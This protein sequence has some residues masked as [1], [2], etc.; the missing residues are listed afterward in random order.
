MITSRGKIA[1]GGLAAVTTP[2]PHFGQICYGENNSYI[3]AD[4]V[5]SGFGLCDLA[6][7]SVVLFN[8]QYYLYATALPIGSI[9]CQSGSDPGMNNQIYG[10]VS[11]DARHWTILNSGEP[12]IANSQTTYYGIG[13]P[14][15]IVM[16]YTYSCTVTGY[17]QGNWAANPTTPWIRVYFTWNGHQPGGNQYLYAEDSTDGVHF[18]LHQVAGVS[19]ILNGNGIQTGGWYPSVKKVAQLGDYPLVISYSS[20]NGL[21]YT[22]VAGA[23]PIFQDIEWTPRNSGAAVPLNPSSVNNLALESDQTGVLI[24]TNGGSFPGAPT[25]QANFWWAQGNVQGVSFPHWLYLG[26]ANTATYFPWI[27]A[28]QWGNCDPQLPLRQP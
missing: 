10:F 5:A 19:A 15:A 28:S 2:R 6:D 1:C 8:R 20:A 18:T 9:G 12:V 24:G 3:K 4:V 13:Q 14:S 11:S 26:Q 16:S 21:A 22:A 17:Y 27:P 25:G 7:P 23:P